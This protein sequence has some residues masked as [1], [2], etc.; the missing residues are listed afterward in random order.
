MSFDVGRRVFLGV[1]IELRLLERIGKGNAVVNHLRQDVVRRTVEDTADLVELVSSKA[2]QHGADDRDAAADRC[3]KHIINAFLLGDFQQFF[4]AGSNQLLVGG[5][6][7]F[8]RQQTAARKLIRSAHAAHYLSHHRDLGV[9]FDHGK[10]RNKFMSIRQRG[11]I[12]QVEH[13]FDLDRLADHARD[14]FGVH[15]KYL[16]HAGAYRAMSHDCCFY[17][18]P[19][20]FPSVLIGQRHRCNVRCCLHSDARISTLLTP[21]ICPARCSRSSTEYFISPVRAAIVTD[22][23]PRIGID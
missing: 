21:A 15:F 23:C 5:A 10:I 14:L 22:A 12:P 17:H 18:N 11:K 6:H 1:T 20:S 7:A 16:V 8:T 13:I 19:V 9:V 2:L 4:T 3:L